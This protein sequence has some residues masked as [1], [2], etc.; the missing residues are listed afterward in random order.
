MHLFLNW[1]QLMKIAAAVQKLDFKYGTWGPLLYLLCDDTR[2]ALHAV[3]ICMC[4]PVL[5]CPFP[6]CSFVSLHV[7]TNLC[8]FH[9]MLRPGAPSRSFSKPTISA[10]TV[11]KLRDQTGSPMM[12]CKRALEE[13][14]MR[15]VCVRVCV[16]VRERETETA[17]MRVHVC[18]YA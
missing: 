14:C 10:Q 18:V 1:A 4:A 9:S 16:C 6:F 2:N 7:V 5:Q 3:F 15:V 17:C 11:K 13:V 12:D 8:T